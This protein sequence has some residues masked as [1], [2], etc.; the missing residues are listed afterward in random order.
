MS[1]YPKSGRQVPPVSFSQNFLTSSRTVK[2]L[3]GRTDLRRDDHVIEIG[4]GKGHVTEV[5]AETCGRVTAVEIDPD[6]CSRTA[7]RTA[8]LSNVEIVNQDFLT[9][10]LPSHGTYKV[11]SNIPFCITTQIIRKISESANPPDETWLVMEKAAARRF[12]GVPRESLRSLLLKPNYEVD[13]VCQ[14]QRDDF[15]PRPSVDV[16]LFHMSKKAQPDILPK[17]WCSYERFV[18]EGM[19]DA[20]GLLR[21]VFTKKQLSMALRYAGMRG[22]PPSGEMRYVQWL[23][24][25]RSYLMRH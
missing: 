16:V 12:A 22:V 3:V 15:H 18:T 19:T 7:Q 25:F 9:W 1:R 24:L 8:G 23:C 5:L 17:Y 10:R 4:S 11:F 21:R 13:I 20:A 2:W 14:L 6:M